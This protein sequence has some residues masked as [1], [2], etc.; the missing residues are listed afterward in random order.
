M[1]DIT[2]MSEELAQKLAARDLIKNR[3]LAETCEVTFTKKDGTERV[4]LC[5]L[6]QE[7]L[8]ETESVKVEKATRPVSPDALPVFDLEKKEWR[9]FRIDAVKAI[10]SVD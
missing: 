3:L 1:T 6:K 10:K 5:T 9:S 7:L 4:M 2:E 8:P